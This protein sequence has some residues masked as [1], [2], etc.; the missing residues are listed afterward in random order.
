[1]AAELEY[2]TPYRIRAYAK[3]NFAGGGDASW[4]N[5]GYVDIVWIN[6]ESNAKIAGNE[7]VARNQPLAM[8]LD[9]TGVNLTEVAYKW[10]VYPKV[11]PANYINSDDRR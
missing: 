4:I 10:R 5:E 6:F 8:R 7:H 9:L 1:M 3:A 11:D 2:M